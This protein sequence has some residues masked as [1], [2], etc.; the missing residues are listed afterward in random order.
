[1]SVEEL[2]LKIIKELRHDSSVSFTDLAVKLDVSEGAIRKHV[3]KLLETGTI[4]QFT[5]KLGKTS[6]INALISVTLDDSKSY[7]SVLE[8]L[9]KES[10]VLNC[11]LTTGKSGIIVVAGFLNTDHL[12][13]FIDNLNALDGVGDVTSKIILE[14][15]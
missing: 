13:N 8:N 7:K 2:D 11:Y 1:M 14:E 3:S 10:E 9:Q 4:K 5:I 15:F 6:M 12:N